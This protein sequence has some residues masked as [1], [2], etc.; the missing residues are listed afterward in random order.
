MLRLI[1]SSVQELNCFQLFGFDILIDQ[2]SIPT[3]LKSTFRLPGMRDTAGPG[4]E[5]PCHRRYTFSRRHPAMGRGKSKSTCCTGKKGAGKVHHWE[6]VA[7]QEAKAEKEEAYEEDHHDERRQQWKKLYR[8]R[9]APAGAVPEKQK[10]PPSPTKL[11]FL[12]STLLHGQSMSAELFMSWRQRHV[13]AE[14]TSEF[15]QR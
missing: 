2:T 11:N 9:R 10:S 5:E 8:G 15:F 14:V 13:A 12:E 4:S 6:I 1:C 7:A 3:S